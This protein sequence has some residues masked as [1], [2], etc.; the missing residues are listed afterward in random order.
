MVIVYTPK[1]TMHPPL[2][3]KSSKVLYFMMFF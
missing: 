1:M 3:F 2:D